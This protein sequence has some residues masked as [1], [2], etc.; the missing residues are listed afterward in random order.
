MH[1]LNN[2]FLLLAQIVVA[3]M[4]FDSCIDICQTLVNNSTPPCYL[5]KYL[6]F[7]HYLWSNSRSNSA[8]IFDSTS[9]WISNSVLD[10]IF[11]LRSSNSTTIHQIYYSALTQL[12]SRTVS[13]RL[14]NESRVRTPLCQN[15]VVNVYLDS[16]RIA[17]QASCCFFSSCAFWDFK[18]RS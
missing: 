15:L 16:W 11:D 12:R 5:K 14:D 6:I 8:P 4:I 17:T 3:E 18:L 13:I 1:R 9:S 7:G 2:D 10:L